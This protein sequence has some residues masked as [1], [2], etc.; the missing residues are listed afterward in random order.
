MP[1]QRRLCSTGM[2]VELRHLW[3][4]AAVATHSSYTAAAREL[5][6][7]QPAL[8]RTVQQLEAVLGVR[9]LERT[10]RSVELTDVGQDFLNRVR[11]VLADLDQAILAAR[12]QQELR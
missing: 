6:I 11:A 10:S 5:L 12:G 8:T 9:L 3:A 1:N 7:G 2:E 4:F